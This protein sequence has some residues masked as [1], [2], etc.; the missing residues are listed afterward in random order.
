MS[1]I[2]QAGLL[3]LNTAGSLVLLVFLL[4]FLLQLVKAD[5]YNPISQFIVRFSNPFLVPLRRIIPGFGGL[6][7][8][9]LVLAYITQLVVMVGI[10]LIAGEQSLPWPYL[11]VWAL[12]GIASLLINIYFWGMVIVIIA[13]FIAP[14]S[15]NPALILV[16]QI[17]N[18]VMQPIRRVMPDLGGIDLS[19]MVLFIGIKMIEI[20]VIYPIAQATMMPQA[21][22]IL[23]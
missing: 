8:A 19:P 11:S 3:L 15:Y 6:D 7:I 9:S 14:N 5:F 22:A 18:P 12:I 1:P 17:I 21:L 20:L 16:T 2:S 10:F 4:R 23:L 13:S